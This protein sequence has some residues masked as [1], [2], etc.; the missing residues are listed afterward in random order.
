[1]VLGY[2]LVRCSTLSKFV[3]PPPLGH[4]AWQSAFSG[5]LQGGVY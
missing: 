3:G 5:D 1:M 2:S 4:G